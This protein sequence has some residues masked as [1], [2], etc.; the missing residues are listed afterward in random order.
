MNN[1]KKAEVE[2]K[3]SN[4][5]ISDRILDYVN[6]LKSSVSAKEGAKDIREELTAEQRYKKRHLSTLKKILIGIG[7]LLVLAL[8]TLIKLFWTLSGYFLQKNL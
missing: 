1:G 6:G 2:K 5:K 3:S 4:K 8:P 7:I